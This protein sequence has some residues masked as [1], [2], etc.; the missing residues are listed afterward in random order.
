MLYLERLD[1]VLLMER[2]D[3]HVPLRLLLYVYVHVYIHVHVCVYTCTC[4]CAF[5]AIGIFSFSFSISFS[6]LCSA[7]YIYLIFHACTSVLVSENFVSSFR[8]THSVLIRRCCVLL[9]SC[10]LF[11][12]MYMY[13]CSNCKSW[14]AVPKHTHTRKGIKTVSKT[15]QHSGGP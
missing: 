6:M 12:V 10:L 8:I 15:T 3:T 4:M 2:W 13:T 9:C 5:E 14:Q 11:Q 7:L 1:P